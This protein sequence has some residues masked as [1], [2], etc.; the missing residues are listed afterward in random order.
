MPKSNPLFLT[1]LALSMFGLAS[2]KQDEIAKPTADNFRVEAPEFTRHQSNE[3]ISWQELRATQTLQLDLADKMKIPN[4]PLGNLKVS[5]T[6]KLKEQNF[7]SQASVSLMGEY[8]IAD[9][10]SE[11]MLLTV[12]A[13]SQP[14]CTFDFTAEDSVIGSTHKF[15]LDGII[16][17]DTSITRKIQFMNYDMKPI[18]PVGMVDW[19][20]RHTTRIELGIFLNSAKLVCTEDEIKL[21]IAVANVSLIE[22][23]IRPEM[24][25]S[26]VQYCRIFTQTPGA[27]NFSERFLFRIGV[28]EIETKMVYQ[29]PQ[30]SVPNQPWLDDQPLKRT[31][32]YARAI[33]HNTS[34]QAIQLQIPKLQRNF[35]L[36]LNGGNNG[37]RTIKGWL[38]PE[39]DSLPEGTK[40]T[41]RTWNIPFQPGEEL[42]VYFR[43]KFDPV[44]A[45]G[46]KFVELYGTKPFRIY[47]IVELAG[48]QVSAKEYDF[49]VTQKLKLG[50]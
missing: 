15:S 33:L 13:E 37:S 46:P 12:G 24:F 11:R 27:R 50:N 6:C 22:L 9:L 35:F 40:E 3:K 43:P 41:E 23:P 18:A 1:S 20:N 45:Y 19:T 49:D 30:L 4:A 16:L 7:S 32:I 39:F 8:S 28:P 36:D 26:P 29:G 47:Q 21:P 31:Q 17:S 25:K 5:A 42:T 48:E 2:C 38:I 44:D 10:L 14:T 34:S